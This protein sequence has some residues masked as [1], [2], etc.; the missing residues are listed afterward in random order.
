MSAKNTKRVP[1]KAVNKCG[2]R[3]KPHCGPGLICDITSGEC[4]D[5]KS[6]EVWGGDYKGQTV[7]VKTV[8]GNKYNFVG[9]KTKKTNVDK[10]IEMNKVALAKYLE[11]WDS[12]D[13]EDVSSPAKK[14]GKR[15]APG[16]PGKKPGKKPA[17]PPTKKP[18]SPGKK[19]AS[20]P[21][22]KAVSVSCADKELEFCQDMVNSKGLSKTHTGVCR[23]N[24]NFTESNGSKCF[25]VANKETFP[26][27]ESTDHRLEI[28]NIS[29]KKKSVIIGPHD[30]IMKIFDIYSDDSNYQGFMSVP[31]KMK[32]GKMGF[33]RR[34]KITSAISPA[35]PSDAIFEEP[36]ITPP[37]PAGKKPGKPSG[38]PAG[39]KLT[40]PPVTKPSKPSSKPS[41][42]KKD[43]DIMSLEDRIAESFRDC[44]KKSA[45]LSE[46]NS[47]S[48]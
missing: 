38:K 2:T 32:S 29:T 18:A 21:K 13:N 45:K 31:K 10:S 20:P 4:L 33:A 3:N 34:T 28:E 40:T 26:D 25:G 16:S 46:E 6:H 35:G 44:M 48:E 27:L 12:V 47:D 7:G 8:D 9:G 42:P 30:E 41:S 14:P 39:K 37:K 19:P 15:P 36:Y 5:M 1:K 43:D 24:K 17:S 11:M 22:K 23:V